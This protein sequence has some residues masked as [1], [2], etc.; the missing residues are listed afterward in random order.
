MTAPQ[1]H[2]DNLLAASTQ[3]LTAARRAVHDDPSAPRPWFQLCALLLARADPDV[4]ALLPRLERFP[5]CAE[6]WQLIGETLL[7]L[8]QPE[9][10]W[11]ALSRALQANEPTS[12]ALLSGAT[13]LQQLDRTDEASALLSDP[14]HRWPA[15]AAIQHARGRLL[16][17]LGAWK[18]AEAALRYAVDLDPGLAG[19]W[20]GLGLVQQDLRQS[21]AA[22][23]AYRT[24]LHTDPG[25]YAAALNLGIVLQDAGNMDAAL[26]AYRT[27]FRLSPSCLNR[28]A[29]ALVS[30]P[31]G[32]LWLRPSA[33]R[34]FLARGGA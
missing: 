13:A 14:R 27:A 31:T 18:D 2:R 7:R 1:S 3:Q 22:A 10:A 16:H 15:D 25:L 5:D 32:R 33:L 8:R 6:G 19:A 4:T 26:E 9:G 28:I 21:N 24:A 17:Q 23:Q 12:S 34:R 29:Q 20:F 30:A 11:I